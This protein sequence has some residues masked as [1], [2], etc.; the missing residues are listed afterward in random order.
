M[1]VGSFLFW[2]PFC[3]V[4]VRDAVLVIVASKYIFEFNKTARRRD[5]KGGCSRAAR[6]GSMPCN[7]QFEM[8]QGAVLNEP[9]KYLQ[10]NCTCHTICV[11]YFDLVL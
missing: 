9:Q 11:Y 3:F 6:Q 4:T 8:Q 7:N 10:Q 1:L 2:S 5:M